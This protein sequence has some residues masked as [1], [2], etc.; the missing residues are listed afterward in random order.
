MTQFVR[1]PESNFEGLAGFPYSPNY[2]V[3]QDLRVH[4][5]D[6]GPKDGPVM[7]L[8]HGMPTWSYL[9]RDAILNASTVKP[10]SIGMATGKKAGCSVAKNPRWVFCCCLPRAWHRPVF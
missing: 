4:Y 7:L 9:Y 6:E 10:S 3:W 8:L 5:I 1:T 2:H